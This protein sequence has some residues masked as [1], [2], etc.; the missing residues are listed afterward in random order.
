ML[1]LILSG[2]NGRM[3]RV[4]EALCGEEPDLH[5]AA[6][7]DILGAT[8][9]EFP[10]FSSPAACT[11]SAQVAVDFSHPAALTSLLGYC[12]K[13]H[14]PVVLATT[15]YTEDQLLEIESAAHAIPIFRSANFSLGINVLAKL[16]RQAAQLLGEDF[17]IEI[18]ERHHNRKVDAPSGTALLL[19]DAISPALSYT[20]EYV[21]DRHAVRKP[22]DPHEIGISSI[23][24]GTIAGDHEILFAGRD[25]WIELRHSA[26]SREV[27]AS[28]ALKA[29][30]FLSRCQ[31][32][33]LYNMD[34]LLE[35]LQT[36]EETS[37]R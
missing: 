26:Q 13:R 6:G 31:N 3:G 37:C 14:L 21:W 1:D 19:A 23:R 35:W 7:F 11:V 5:I 32:P 2:C 34:D 22:R 24:G 17:D 29:A 8:D 15:G 25:E 30:R 10:V 33:G 27:F 9:R 20:P 4:L 16:A 18:V 28:G 36:D 12:V